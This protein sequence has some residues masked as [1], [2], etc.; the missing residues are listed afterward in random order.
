MDNRIEPSE[1][2]YHSIDDNQWLLIGLFFRPY[3]IHSIQASEDEEPSRAIQKLNHLPSSY[4]PFSNNSL[5]AL[6]EQGEKYESQ[7]YEYSDIFRC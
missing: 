1:T 6:L 3:S 4:L 5:L 2:Q 7:V